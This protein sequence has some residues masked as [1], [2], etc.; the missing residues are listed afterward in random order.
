LRCAVSGVIPG[1]IAGLHRRTLDLFKATP[2]Q[3]AKYI[4]FLAKFSRSPRQ[5]LDSFV[6]DDSKAGPRV[7]PQL[8]LYMAV[9]AGIALLLTLI[10]TAVGMAPHSSWIVTVVGRMDEKVLPLAVL[11]LVVIIAVV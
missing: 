1:G 8:L 9:S 4:D 10:G 3:V 7:S 11:A 6:T 5:A 2:D